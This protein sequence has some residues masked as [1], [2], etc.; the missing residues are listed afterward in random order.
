MS[1]FLQVK[2]PDWHIQP[3]DSA[4]FPRCAWYSV[5]CRAYGTAEQFIHKGAGFCLV[6]AKEILAEV[7]LTPAVHGIREIGVRTQEA[8][9]GQGYGTFLCAYGIEICEQLGERVY[10]NTA[11]QNAAS[12]AIAR[13]LGFRR[14]RVYPVRIWRTSDAEGF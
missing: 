4:L 2:L 3:I 8:Y 11:Q 1:V 6:G 9:R 12:L 13:K 5:I 7:Y 14:E 10:W